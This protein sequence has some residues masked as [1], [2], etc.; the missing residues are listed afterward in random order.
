LVVRLSPLEKLGA[1]RGDVRVPGGEDFAAVEGGR[2]AARVGLAA[3]SPFGRL[4]VSVRDPESTVAAIG[5]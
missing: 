5:V 1:F 2:P 3:E 4:V